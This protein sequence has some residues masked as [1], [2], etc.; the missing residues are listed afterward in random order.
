[1]NKELMFSS[2][3]QTW[4]TPK[5]FFC[6]LN[7]IFRFELDVCATDLTAKCNKYFTP[8][9]DGLKQ[10][11]NGICWCNPPYSRE[12]PKWTKKA[13]EESEKNSSTVVMLIPARPDTKIWHEIIFPYARGIF[14]IKG[15]LKFGDS[16]NSAPFPSALVVFSKYPVNGL[17]KDYLKYTGHGIWR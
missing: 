8:K 5:D 17:I 14:F 2:N 4:E 11:W 13:Y 7:E 16:R 12:L 10:D 9:E 15:R 1:M 6:E 3:D